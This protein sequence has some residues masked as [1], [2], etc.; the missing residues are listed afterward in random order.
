MRVIAV[1]GAQ[2]LVFDGRGED[3]W[4]MAHIREGDT[5]W[6]SQKFV[7]L[8]ALGGWQP[9]GSETAAGERR[10][11][12]PEGV[13][14]YGQPIGAI[15]TK[16]PLRQVKAHVST[17][18]KWRD[19]K[20]GDRFIDAT[21]TTMEVIQLQP[22]ADGEAQAFQQYASRHEGVS[23]ADLNWDA[24]M[25][26]KAKAEWEAQDR[27]MILLRH[28][29]PNAGRWAPAD[30]VS[31]PE[32]EFQRAPSV[33]DPF[34]A[35]IIEPARAAMRAREVPG[36]GGSGAGPSAARDPAGAEDF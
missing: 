15:I 5:D 2:E 7:T 20:V 6:P 21:G 33:G 36:R 19:L 30:G 18:V 23:I 3:G 29:G 9:L 14:K 32:H 1:R 31:S 27:K 22:W 34:M 10:V 11:R 24:E 26:A 28:D 25:A 17:V 12:T 8:F 16:D 4:S 13:E 35:E